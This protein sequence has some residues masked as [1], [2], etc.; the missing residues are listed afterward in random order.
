[1]VLTLSRSLELVAPLEVGSQAEGA[2]VQASSLI[3]HPYTHARGAT[4]SPSRGVRY[5]KVF[6]AAR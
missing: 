6:L 5:S 3:I 2:G 4:S 1:V